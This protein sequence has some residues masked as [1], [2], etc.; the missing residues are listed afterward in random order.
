VVQFGRGRR[1]ATTALAAVAACLLAAPQVAGAGSDEPDADAVLT[2]TADLSAE[3]D[4]GDLLAVRVTIAADRL[5]D[6]TVVVSAGAGF[7]VRRDVQ[8]AGGSTEEFWVLLPSSELNGADA[9][10][11][12]V[13]DADTIDSDRL[14]FSH[15]PDTDVAGVLPRLVALAGE[16][17]A[18]ATVS[19]D[20]RRVQLVSV[21]V[22]LLAVG[23]GALDQLDVV[24]ATSADLAQLDDSA[25][26]TLLAWV[27]RGGQLVL[28]DADDLDALPADWRPGDAGYALAG[29]GEVRVVDG[30]LAAGEWGDAFAPTELGVQDSPTGFT[31]LDMMIDPRL[32]LSQRAGVELP[33]L[34]TIIAVLGGYVVVIGPI[35]YLVLRRARRLTAAWV[36]IPAVA[37]LVGAGV[38]VTGSG[39]RSSGRPT[40]NV[41]AESSAV[42]TD[43]TVEAL[44]F[45]RGGGSASVSLPGGWTAAGR[46]TFGWFDSSSQSTATLVEGD[47]EPRLETRLDPGQIA[48]LQARGHDP[49]TLLDV[50]AAAHTDRI[51]G[52]V[53]N[54]S[55]APLRSVAVFAAGRA[56][57]VGDLDVGA[58]ATYT[59]DR[60]LERADPYTSALGTAWPQANQLFGPTGN[61]EIQIEGGVDLGVWTSFASRVADGLYPAGFVRVAGWT[62][63]LAVPT[64]GAF[65]TTT[66]VTRLAPI[67]VADGSGTPAT[68]IRW[69]WITSPYDPS[70]GALE[71]PVLRYVVPAGAPT[72][73]L[74]FSVPQGVTKIEVLGADGKW[75]TLAEAGGGSD[76]VA[77]PERRVVRGS[78]VIRVT[79]DQTIGIDPVGAV[80]VLR[81]DAS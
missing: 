67:G 21:P 10:I 24:A 54:T 5:I 68:A 66:L 70:S 37:V 14:R 64:G 79:L 43:R 52:T 1:L 28:D 30:L 75:S 33:D 74:S 62:D 34:T 42:G 51:E 26:A 40:A 27:D 20:L 78:V 17:P 65:A 41:T 57:L 44:V 45:S 56:V 73:A 2:A 38:V 4:Q 23:V 60:P 58:S 9:R 55:G 31:G 69:G 53:T 47:G 11:D 77:V 80:P 63:D 8:V 13:D 48:V 35:M 71:P 76:R 6:G 59:I 19:G 50:T 72:D 29:R 39:W 25:L 16:P 61:S 3:F 81:G 22:E 32:T 15:D 36:L 12:L 46:S 49:A 7:E 18:R